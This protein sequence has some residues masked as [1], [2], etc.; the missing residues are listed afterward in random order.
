LDQPR[1]PA[2][3]RHGGGGGGTGRQP[4]GRGR[5]PPAPAGGDLAQGD[6]AAPLVAGPLTPAPRPGRRR[7]DDGAP[8]FHRRGGAGGDL[9]RRPAAGRP[10]R[11]EGVSAVA[12]AG[13]ATTER[14]RYGA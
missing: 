10:G 3:F 2:G 5:V 1:R 4:G 12:L 14:P 13:P 11:G 6:A 7:A 8:V 9:L